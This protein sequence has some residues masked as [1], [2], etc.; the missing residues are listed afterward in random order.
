[1]ISYA[2]PLIYL[3]ERIDCY[4]CS[5]LEA[6]VVVAAEAAQEWNDRQEEVYCGL[7]LLH[8]QEYRHWA[9]FWKTVDYRHSA[10]VR[11]AVEVEVAVEGG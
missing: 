1:M 2:S 4:Y 9:Y 10:G 8:R 3:S 5:L 6:V 11:L 7:A